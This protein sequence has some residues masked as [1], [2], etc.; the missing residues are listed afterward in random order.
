MLY[1]RICDSAVGCLVDFLLLLIFI[2]III[3]IIIINVINLLDFGIYFK[4]KS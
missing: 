3:I 4:V 2:I 1:C